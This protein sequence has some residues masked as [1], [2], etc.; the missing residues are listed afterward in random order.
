NF[1]NNLI[2]ILESK[3]FAVKRVQ[4][5]DTSGH[6]EIFKYTKAK[7][8]ADHQERIKNAYKIDADTAQRI[9]QQNQNDHAQLIR[10]KRLHL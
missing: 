4:Q 6:A 2:W 1:A 9:Q 5:F 7:I 8:K 10:L 3:K